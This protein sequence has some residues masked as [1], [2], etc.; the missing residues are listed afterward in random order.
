MTVRIAENAAFD[1]DAVTS[2]G[3]VRS[4]LPVPVVGEMAYGHL[5]GAVNGGRPTARLRS[6][7]GG[8]YVKKL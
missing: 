7:G 3:G 4:E 8:I 1:L 5:K 2:G 6:G